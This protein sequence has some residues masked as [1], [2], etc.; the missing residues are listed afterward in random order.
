MAT[1]DEVGRARRRAPELDDEREIDFGRIGRSI[2]D[3]W[4]LVLAAVLVGALLGYFSSVSSGEVYSARTTIYLGQPL[5][6]TG[7]AQ[8][9]S[10]ATNPSTVSEIVR[11]DEVVAKVA[12]DLGI[13]PRALR[14]GISTRQIVAA[15]TSASARANTNP[16]VQ[17]AVRGDW[18]GDTTAR[19][20]NALAEEVVTRVSEYVDV[21]AKAL[22]DRLDS[23]NRELEAIDVKIDRL[24]QLAAQGGPNADTDLI[25]ASLAE[26]RR[27]QLVEDKTD[28][29]TLLTLARNVE[30]GKQ[31]TIGQASRV[32]AQSSRSSIVVGALIGLLVGI[33]LALLWTPV[34]RRV[35]P[36]S[37]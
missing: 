35:R 13:Q 15:G 11:S 28:T 17:I 19:A 10:L 27:G 24:N 29:E 5:S 30:R 18:K 16:L 32:P 21:K 23:E 9:Q 7:N 31:V 2:L 37:A 6:P 26:Q 36:A 12:E 25:L 4:W 22:Q 20:A 33:V 8:I 14:N 1:E 34:M 3:R